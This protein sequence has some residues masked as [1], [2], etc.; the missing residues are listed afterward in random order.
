MSIYMQGST[1]LDRRLDPISRSHS[2][3][4]LDQ[5]NI[6]VARRFIDRVPSRHVS[7]DFNKPARAHSPTPLRVRNENL[8]SCAVKAAEPGTGQADEQAPYEEVGPRR[9]WSQRTVS[10]ARFPSQESVQRLP[11]PPCDDPVIAKAVEGSIKQARSVTLASAASQT[12]W[13]G[14]ENSFRQ[15]IRALNKKKGKQRSVQPHGERWSLDEVGE[16]QMRPRSGERGKARSTHRKS[17]SWASSSSAFV[18][19]IR[20]A[21]QS[22]STFSET[23]TF[24][25]E[26]PSF[27]RSTVRWSN[28][29]HSNLHPSTDESVGSGSFADEDFWE[30]SMKRRQILD[31][32]LDSEESYVSD[33]KVLLNVSCSLPCQAD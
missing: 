4:S 8:Q 24:R 26:E 33:L 9:R 11:L 17:T 19:A 21:R 22:L 7:E 28:Q 2:F 31:E 32:L 20:S 10:S 27:Q 16:G 3:V 30:R 14:P 23:P 15:W 5:E 6:D 12:S 25:T 29:S 18:T 13:R 1:A